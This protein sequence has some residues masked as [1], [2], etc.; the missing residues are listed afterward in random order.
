MSY[1]DE[2]GMYLDTFD[3]TKTKLISDL[4]EIFGDGVNT[5]ATVGDGVG[6]AMAVASRGRVESS[7]GS[8]AQDTKQKARA[9]IGGKARP[10]WDGRGMV[11]SRGA[12]GWRC[13]S[14]RARLR[15]QIDLD[16]EDDLALHLL[17]ALVHEEVLQH[18]D[19]AEEGG[20][21]FDRER[22]LAE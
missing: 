21:G 10:R 5:D 1:V 17:L 18:G 20:S 7:A 19:S 12:S 22:C 4:N 6:E 11:R 9:R 3:E 15:G 2:T 8:G 13:G 14:A 16:K